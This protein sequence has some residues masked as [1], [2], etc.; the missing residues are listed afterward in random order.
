MRLARQRRHGDGGGG[1]RIL[2]HEIE[3]R[4]VLLIRPV[5]LAD[6]LRIVDIADIQ[7]DETLV[8][9]RQI[10]AVVPDGHVMDHDSGC[11]QAE[12]G[13]GCR[14]GR[15]VLRRPPGSHCDFGWALSHARIPPPRYVRRVSRVRDVDNLEDFSDE[16]VRPEGGKCVSAIGRLVDPQSVER[17]SHG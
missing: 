9:H 3:R 17:R 8:A 13:R 7:D 5:D 2:D 4:T 11:R 6:S 14:A 10:A 15:F 1:R 16:S 12:L